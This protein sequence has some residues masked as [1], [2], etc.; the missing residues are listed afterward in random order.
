M[1]AMQSGTSDLLA[2]FAAP[3]AAV[4]S[5]GP[6]P[7]VLFASGWGMCSLLVGASLGCLF[8][9]AARASRDLNYEFGF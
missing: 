8:G 2:L 3:A 9:A 7:S 1:A 5:L 6:Q 4:L